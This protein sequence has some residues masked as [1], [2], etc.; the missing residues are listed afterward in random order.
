M[1]ASRNTRLTNLIL[2]HVT[3]FFSPL[4]APRPTFI[5]VHQIRSDPTVNEPTTIVTSLAI[6]EYAAVSVSMAL[7]RFGTDSARSRRRQILFDKGT[8][9]NDAVNR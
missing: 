6:L 4:P 1:V 5:L 9:F 2:P 7:C 8:L 3:T